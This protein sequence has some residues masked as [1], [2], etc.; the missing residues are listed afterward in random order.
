MFFGG[1]FQTSDDYPFGQRIVSFNIDGIKSIIDH[2]IQIGRNA[3]HIAL[4]HI[5]GIDGKAD[6]AEIQSI[7]HSKGIPEIGIFI[8]FE[9]GGR[10][11]QLTKFFKGTIA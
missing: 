8:V 7:V 5:V 10:K 11:S 1:L 3:R 9:P 6:T 4:E 2:K